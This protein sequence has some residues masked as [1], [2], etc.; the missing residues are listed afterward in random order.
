MNIRRNKDQ[1]YNYKAGITIIEIKV[2]QDHN[3]FMNVI[4]ESKQTT[5]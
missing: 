5:Y 4:I 2:L 3:D 1:I